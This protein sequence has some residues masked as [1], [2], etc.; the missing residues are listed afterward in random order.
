MLLFLFRVVLG[1][2]FLSTV[3]SIPRLIAF[4]VDDTS[5][6]I[7]YGYEGDWI[8]FTDQPYQMGLFNNTGTTSHIQGA[9][10]RFTFLGMF[11]LCRLVNRALMGLQG[12]GIDYWSSRV[13]FE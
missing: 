13:R 12:V 8:T 7:N 2:S 4:E 11:T 5:P 3:R 1:L 6:R 10:L 9:L